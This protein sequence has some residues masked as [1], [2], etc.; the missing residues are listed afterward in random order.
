MAVDIAGLIYQ[1]IF[2]HHI[3]GW[4]SGHGCTHSSEC[5]SS[6]PEQMVSTATSG[7]GATG[8]FISRRSRANPDVIVVS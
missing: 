1:E 6:E 8:R 4:F 2:V 5:T 3:T 7:T